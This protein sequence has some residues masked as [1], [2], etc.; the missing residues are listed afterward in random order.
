MC[1]GVGPGVVGRAM[2]GVGPHMQ[3]GVATYVLGRHMRWVGHEGYECGHVP[4]VWPRRG[5]AMCVV[6]MWPCAV[7]WP[8]QEGYECGHVLWVLSYHV[9]WVWLYAGV[10][11]WLAWGRWPRKAV[12]VAM[13]CM[14]C[15]CGHM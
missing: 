14:C 5:V 11:W 6:K 13:P 3:R 12:G 15:G 8:S 2:C 1:G 4:W 9:L 10:R 7:V